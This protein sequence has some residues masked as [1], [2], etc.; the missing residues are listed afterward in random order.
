[1]DKTAEAYSN[2]RKVQLTWKDAEKAEKGKNNSSL[3]SESVARS[4]QKIEHE[5]RGSR[6]KD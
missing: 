4:S 3:N 5:I 2:T 6:Q 1:M